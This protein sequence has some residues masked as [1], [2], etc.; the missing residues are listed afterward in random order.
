LIGSGIAGSR[1]YSGETNG[2]NFDTV[3]ESP[4]ALRFMTPA[5]GGGSERGSIVS[6]DRKKSK[7]GSK[8]G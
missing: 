2:N 5:L 8:T 1:I 6:K 4:G 3:M 7:K